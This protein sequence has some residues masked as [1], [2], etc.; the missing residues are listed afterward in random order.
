MGDAGLFYSFKIVGVVLDGGGGAAVGLHIGVK[1]RELLLRGPPADQH[2]PGVLVPRRAAGP[3]ALTGAAPARCALAAAGGGFLG[4][5]GRFRLG[6]ALGA[7]FGLLSGAGLGGAGGFLPAAVLLALL[8]G[9]IFLL[10]GP[11]ALLAAALPSVLG[12]GGGLVGR[13][14]AAP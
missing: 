2:Q 4:R 10:G 12:L 3:A 9:L 11:P 1:A 7:L 5:A 13:G 8:L 6:G 14:R